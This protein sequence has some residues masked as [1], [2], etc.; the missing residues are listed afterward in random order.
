MN[1]NTFFSFVTIAVLSGTLLLSCGKE[2][3]KDN[4]SNPSP[5]PTLA[6]NVIPT[7]S[8]LIERYENEGF[9]TKDLYRVII[10]KPANLSVE[11]AELERQARAKA[12]ASLKKYI[13]AGGKSLTSNTNAEIL[14]LI[15]NSGSI[16]KIS[17]DDKILYVLD[18]HRQG[19]RSYVDSLGQ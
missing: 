4:G 10:V 3:I 5:A 9:I 13:T 12:I 7:P 1:P 18:I 14:N 16:K 17:V 6:P 8:V 2:T 15:G 11:D 19:C